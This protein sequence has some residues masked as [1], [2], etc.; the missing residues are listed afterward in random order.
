[1]STRRRPQVRFASFV[2]FATIALFKTSVCVLFIDP[3][4]TR[5]SRTVSS[6]LAETTC[7]PSGENLAEFT[8]LE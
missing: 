4:R 3:H 1:M 5:H 8:H 7:V 6:P 2:V